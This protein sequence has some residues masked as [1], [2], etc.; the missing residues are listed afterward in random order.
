VSEQTNES[1]Q[2]P[3]KVKFRHKKSTKMATKA[4]K[5]TLTANQRDK[6]KYQIPLYKNWP[7]SI[8]HQKVTPVARRPWTYYKNQDIKNK[9]RRIKNYQQA[10][11]DTSWWRPTRSL[12][13]LDP[14]LQ[15]ILNNLPLLKPYST[16]TKTWKISVLN[17]PMLGPFRDKFKRGYEGQFLKSRFHGWGVFVRDQGRYVYEGEFIDGK[18]DGWGRQVASNGEV[19]EGIWSKGVFTGERSQFDFDAKKVI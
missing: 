18:E 5:R 19:L 13:K 11:V 9:D 10:N 3:K 2:K 14:E 17:S 7:H 12:P 6:F 8:Y 1:T 16:I 4:A 15:L